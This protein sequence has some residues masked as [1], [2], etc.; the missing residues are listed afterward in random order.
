MKPPAPTNCAKSPKRARRFPD[1]LGFTLVEMMIALVL[2]GVGLM[3]LAQ[4]LPSGLSV[5]DKAR[6]MSVATNLSQ[7][8]VERLRDL[9]YDHADLAPGGHTDLT[10]LGNYARRW[11]VENNTPAPDMKRVTVQVS[12]RTNSPDSMSIMTTQIAR[13]SR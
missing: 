7:E 3:A 5:R 9:P 1:D 10:P 8:A 2:F 11:T 12:F 4:S 6:R 13:G